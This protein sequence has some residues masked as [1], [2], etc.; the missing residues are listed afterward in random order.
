MPATS[1]GMTVEVDAGYV[2]NALA[3]KVESFGLARRAGLEQGA[4]R[5]R[6]WRAAVAEAIDDRIA[7]VAAEIPQR[8]LDAGRR[9]PPLVF[10]E[11]EQ[12]P[13]LE[14]DV[15]VEARG[16]DG[17]DRLLALDQPF[18]DLVEHVVGRQ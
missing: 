15:A 16:D 18:Q 8:H 2:G 13:D 7:A 4:V 17:G 6:Q 3:L 12:A 11:I 10:G 1:A 14:H 9:L 5:F